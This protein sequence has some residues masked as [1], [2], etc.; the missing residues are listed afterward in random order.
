MKKTYRHLAATLLLATAVAPA[1]AQEFRTAAFMQTNNYR[2][3]INPAMLDEAYVG[4][5]FFGQINVGATGNFGLKNFVYKLDGN[6]RYDLTTFMSPT[7]SAGEFLGDLH[8]KNR[9]DVYINYNIFSV[10]FKAFKGINLVEL[11]LRSNTNVS[12]PYEL[13]EFM[14]TTGAKETYHLQ[15]IGVRSQNYLELALGHS[16]RINDQWTVGAKLKFLFGGA[17]ADFSADQL[18]VTMNGDQWRIV[19]DA[20]LKAA[21]LSSEF[22]YED[23]SKNAPDGRR[24]VKGIDDVSFGLP[25]FGMGVDLGATFKV[26]KDLTLSAAI[27]DLGFI[28]WSK[29]K[30]AS[31]RGDY[32]FDGF[33]DIYAGSNNTG[34][35]K[36]GDQFETLGD[37]LEEMFS[38]YDDGEGSSSQALAATINIGAEYTLPA[39]RNLRFGFLY[40]SR[41]HGLYSYHQGLLSA[42]IRPVKCLEAS[43][44]T[45]VSSTGCTFG[46][47]LS[48]RAKHYNF[49]IG[50]DRIFGKVS[51]EF[52]P[53]NS[54]NAN[55]TMGMSFPLR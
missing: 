26:T 35:N 50:S 25:G 16:H 47:A 7:V 12:L 33:E 37:D 38:V 11:N 21:V 19:G 53:L 1:A 24:R 15:D 29:V 2:H 4:M 5:P 27:N 46:A 6:P 40:T 17:Y 22:D 43:V 34:G 10:G 48:L 3:Q 44:N 55:V 54:L 30:N 36:L 18:D 28:N 52:I 8:D 45:A 32:T 14:K 51:K 41:L 49:F 42:T 9:A 13:F 23:P 31:S 39:Y 20:R